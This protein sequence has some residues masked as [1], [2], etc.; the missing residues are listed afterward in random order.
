[1]DYKEAWF[2]LK[3]LLQRADYEIWKLVDHKTEEKELIR[4]RGK[5]EGI[6]LALSYMDGET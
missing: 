2:E 3:E 5:H 1:M 6:R 4:L